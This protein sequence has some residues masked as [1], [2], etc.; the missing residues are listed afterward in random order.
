MGNNRDELV[1]LRQSIAM[2][3]LKLGIDSP[4]LENY[5]LENARQIN[6]GWNSLAAEIYKKVEKVDV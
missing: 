3:A 4:L 6:M 1:M 5:T 2:I